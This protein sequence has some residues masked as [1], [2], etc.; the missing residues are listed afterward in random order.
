MDR[1]EF[2]KLVSLAGVGTPFFLNGMPSRVMNQFMDMQMSCDAVNDRILVIVRMSGAND[3]LNTVIPVNQYDQYAILRPDIKI[4]K[5]GAN[6]YIPLDTT[7]NTARL[8]GLHPKMTGFKGLYD[9]GKML[10]MNGVGYPN[11]NYSHFRSE[12]LMQAGKDG[13]E[14]N[15]DLYSG[16]FGRYIGALHPGLSGNPTT[17]NPDPLAIQ[18]ANL[19]PSIFFEHSTERNIEYNLTPI[20]NN[21]FGQLKRSSSETTET[22]IPTASEYTDLLNY[23]KGIELSMDKYFNRV[24]A[25][26]NAGSNSAVTYPDNSLGKQLKTVARLVKGGSKT[27]IFQVN[28][29]GF[30]THVGQVTTGSTHDGV[31]AGLLKQ[32]SDSIAAF[33]AD[34]KNLGFEDKV[35]TVTFS[36]F[37]RQVKQNANKGTDHGDLAPFFVIGNSVSGG[38]LGN[39]PVFSNTT[40]YYYNQSQRQFDYRQIFASILQ[41]WLGADTSLMLSSEMNDFVVGGKKVAVIKNEK[42]AGVVCGNLSTSNVNTSNEIKVYPVPTSSFLYIDFGKLR[43][44]TV[45][46]QLID[47]SGRVLL[48]GKNNNFNQKIE[49][50]TSSIKNGNYLLH[51][52]TDTQKHTQKVIVRH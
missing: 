16:I 19:N 20:Q 43:P 33:Q 27:K 29:N 7:V 15:P 13:T 2:L 1:K 39:H 46:Y 40:G 14:P 23:I 4:A 18:F 22:A 24:T 5:T 50:D 34:I 42:T 28:L 6:G 31:H 10:V 48:S 37:G 9:S 25:V 44:S 26:F 51:V 41:D 8:V 52:Q 36:E 12:Y 38:I 30:D 11:P 35:L 21:F 49:L 3:G 32:V 45:E 17:K 47:Y